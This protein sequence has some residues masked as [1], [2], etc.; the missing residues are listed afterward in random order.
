MALR[1]SPKSVANLQHEYSEQFVG[2]KK[3]ILLYVL[4]Q[5]RKTLNSIAQRKIYFRFR[6]LFF[7][8]FYILRN[9]FLRSNVELIT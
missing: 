1:P 5:T 2:K 3:Y 6:F 4:G 9:K 8:S 7:P